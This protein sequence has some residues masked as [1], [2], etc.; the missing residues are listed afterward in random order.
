MITMQ[1]TRELA[2][3]LRRGGSVQIGRI[4]MQEAGAD[5]VQVVIGDR[6]DVVQVDV[7][8][9]QLDALGAAHRAGRVV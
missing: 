5:H 1:Q 7:F 3:A 2:D 9:A 4:Q 6:S 8:L